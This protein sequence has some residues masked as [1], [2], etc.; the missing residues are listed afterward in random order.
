[1]QLFCLQFFAY[2]RKLPAYSGAFHLQLT[3]LAF[4]LTIGAFSVTI[5]AFL[6]TIG[7]FFAYSAKLRLIRALRL[8]C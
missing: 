5:L 4:L 1:M 2:S 7:A 3:A 8:Q 6:L